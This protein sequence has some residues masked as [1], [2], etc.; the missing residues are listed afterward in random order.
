MTVSVEKENI[1]GDGSVASV[2][3]RPGDML[4]LAREAKGMSLADVAERTRIS[5]RQLEAVER[6]DFA[7]LPGLPYAV[8]FSRAYARAV[9]ADEVA[10]SRL[11]REEIGAHGPGDPYQMFEP[12]DPARVPPRWLAVIAAVLAVLLAIG[13]GVWRAQIN[14]PPTDT[15][16][17]GDTTAAPVVAGPAP[18]ARAVNAPATTGGPVVLTATSD[19]WLRIYDQTG[20]RLLEK[21]MKQGESYTV[22]ATANNPMIL[23]GRPDALA[24]TVAG[25]TVPP[26]GPPEKTIADVP[27]SASALLARGTAPAITQPP[28]SAQTAVQPTPSSAVPENSAAAVR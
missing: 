27:I 5:T 28:G 21:Q 16:L 26:L 11:V 6:S 10:I 25:R 23:T 22:P 3:D 12:A 14:S 20:T 15:E 9:G 8:G 18:T 7:A 13:Y 19:V 24:V 17:S 1:E 4:R 2:V